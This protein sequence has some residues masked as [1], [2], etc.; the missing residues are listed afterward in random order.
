MK[1]NS[2][3]K[4]GIKAWLVVFS[5]AWFF[6]YE[7]LQM[8][9]LNAL[10]PGLMHDLGLS[11]IHLA[12]LSDTFLFA[13]ILVLI[14]SGLIIDR[15][16]PRKVL[17]TTLA[18]AIVGTLIFSFTSSLAVACFCQFLGGIGAAFSFLILITLATQ[19]F[20]SAKIGLGIGL[21]VPFA[22][23]GGVVAETPL[24][25][26][27]SAIGWR[28]SLQIISGLGVLILLNAFIFVRD[29]SN[30]QENNLIVS[31]FQNLIN[32][33][34]LIVKKPKNWLC[35]FYTGLL[36][37]PIMIFDSLYGNMY[38]KQVYHLTNV[39][40]SYIN[41][42]IFLGT[43]IGS[44]IFGWVS[45]RGDSRR[46]PMLIGALG[47][48]LVII[49]VVY[50]ENLTYSL[51]IVLFFALGLFTSAQVI[52]YPAVVESNPVNISS[53]ATGFISI[54]IMGTGAFSQPL[55]GWLMKLN[56]NGKI[57]HSTALFSTAD[58]H[59]ALAILPLS[60]ILSFL[61]ACF[62]QK[63]KTY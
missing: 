24:T 39:S 62:I 51:L 37:L 13:T 50:Q 53:T 44:P 55:F 36:N 8:N 19:W 20:S 25:I 30:K 32:S 60:F 46:A 52:S 14:P 12:F 29:S 54:L 34:L 5:G 3:K 11:S 59:L 17:L 16:Q 2:K 21:S 40:A 15:F 43:I 28:H 23:L 38:L 61:A 22:M 1:N 27:N 35:G 49:S 57:V 33:L 47:S 41:S 26:L 42:M 9:M 10:S 48:L 18:I 6:F 58:Y 45:D 63:K 4:D 56:W 31:G 7:F